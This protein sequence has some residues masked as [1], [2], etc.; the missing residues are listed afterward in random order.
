MPESFDVPYYEG[1]APRKYKESL[2][3]ILI[4]IIIGI[5]LLGKTTTFLC[6]VPGLSSL[7]CGGEQ[8]NFLIL[9]DLT[10]GG[11][12]E[13]TKVVAPELGI[14]LNGSIARSDY[15]MQYVEATPDLIGTTG[16]L[17][18]GFDVVIM[19][20]ER[21]YTRSAKE[22]IREYIQG[23]GKVIL[24]GDAGTTDPDEPTLRGWGIIG[25]MPVEL[26]FDANIDAPLKF[27]NNTN[28]QRLELRVLDVFNEIV[29]GYGP[30]F[31]IHND[32]K[33]TCNDNLQVI[34][35]NVAPGGSPIAFL[36]GTVNEKKTLRPAVVTRDTGFIGG[37]VVYFAYDPGCTP[38]MFI[39]TVK[40][41][42]G[43]GL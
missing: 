30:R 32:A 18:K 6:N 12:A 9:G 10:A 35:V 24:I 19:V 31:T 42:T 15:H 43:K 1:A 26:G 13:P 37:K 11:A 7:F 20:G 22:R 4:L 40:W 29:K 3:P 5:V 39:S 27:T 25:E 41:L 2:I 23:G 38:S 17:L 36:A 16:S 33:P 21:A 8:V 14:F 28:V 34:D